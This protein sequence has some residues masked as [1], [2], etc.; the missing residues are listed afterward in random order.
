MALWDSSE[1]YGQVSRFLHWGMADG[2]M[3]VVPIIALI[4]QYG[5]GRAFE[6]FGIPVFSRFESDEIEWMTD[7]GGPLHGEL[8]WG[9]FALIA[10]HIFM[11]YWHRRHPNHT[12][13]LPRMWR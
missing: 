4:R 2:L 11:T 12:D 3:F 10:G 6:P 7:L 9:L 13:V 8:G 5:S 1:R